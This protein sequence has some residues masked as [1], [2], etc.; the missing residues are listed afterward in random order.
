MVFSSTTF[1]LAFLP[2]VAILYYI[3]PRKL[4]NG[5]L[6]VFSLLFYGWGE[7]KY[8]LIMLFSTVFDYCNGL[9]IGHFRSK[10]RA[11]GAKA[12]LVISVVGNLAIL[13]FFK[14]TD[15]A[16][17]NLNGLLGTAI[18]AL[19]LLLPIGISFYTFQ[20]MSYT[21]DVYRGLVPPQRNIVDFGAYVTLFP[22]LIAG[23]IVQYK[24]VAYDLEH[25]RESVS[26]ASEGLQRLVIGLGK[27]VLI[28]NQ[29]GAIWEDIA[30]MSDPT[31]VTAWI[32]AIAYTFQIYFDF[33]GYSDMAIGLGHFFGFHFLENFNYPYESR[34]VT[35]FW[36]RWHISLS[37]WFRDYVYIPLGGSREGTARTYLN[38]LAVWVLTGLWH[39]STLNFLLW[40]L[41]L[42]ALIALERAGWGRVLARSRVISRVYMVLMI[43]LSWMLF[44]IPSVSRIGVYLGRLFPLVSQ[45]IAVNAGDW[46]QYGKQYWWLLVLGIVFSTPGPEKLWNRIRGTWLGTVIL[47]LLFWACVYCMSVATN[48]P[49]M[50]FSF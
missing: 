30:A 35:E 15:F 27:K 29:M 20:T 44:A 25:R 43:P 13:G 48:D 36:R 41:L 22:Q 9:A 26:E 4:R 21:I 32:G 46:L 16:I 34:S 37:S 31:A 23:P 1:L 11:G 18:P 28:A 47:A 50:Y 42:F 45:G 3:C 38:L 24:T 14:Y 40:G 5:L 33:S 8:I 19:G 12:V 6:L 10:G 7:P 39:G 17:S 49:F 2:L